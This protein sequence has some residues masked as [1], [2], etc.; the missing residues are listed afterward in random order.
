V[1]APHP[2][3]EEVKRKEMVCIDP[4]VETECMFCHRPITVMSR[5]RGRPSFVWCHDCT[6][7]F[8]EWCNWSH[9]ITTH[10]LLAQ[11]VNLFKIRPNEPGV[12]WMEMV[13]ELE[14]LR[15]WEVK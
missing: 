8:D 14:R 10:Q 2:Q 11:A 1:A 15:I 6:H 13:S 4:L 5:R 9:E 7:N 12:E 3:T